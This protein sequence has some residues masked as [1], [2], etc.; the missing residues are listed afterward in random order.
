MN[1]PN[2]NLPLGRPTPL[3]PPTTG[4]EED[5]KALHKGRGKMI[6]F[7][8]VV[9][10]AA[11]GG[12]VAFMAMGQSDELYSELGRN[13]NAQDREHFNRFWGCAFQGVVQV[14]N[15]Q[16]VEYQI[17]KRAR[18]GGRRY[19]KLVREQCMPMIAPMRT[20]LDGMVA[21]P[22]LQS[23]VHQLAER[24]G[25]LQSAWSEFVAHLD[26]GEYDPEDD[27]SVGHVRKIAKGW[28]DYKVRRAAVA[29]S[30]N[31]RLGRA[32]E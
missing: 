15:N 25:E 14:R 24:I 16:D 11:V 8:V 31:K 13:L 4:I 3:G 18:Q 21:P 9:V 26:S 2:E 32:V 23:E 7:A 22:E 10:L 6:A 28:Y 29:K 17:Q 20:K 1:D 5:E 12:L 30:I 19:G 27:V